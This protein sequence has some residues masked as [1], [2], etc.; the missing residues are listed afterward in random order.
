[1]AT[2]VPDASERLW[3]TDP[4]STDSDKDGVPDAVELAMRCMG[5]QLMCKPR[6]SNGDGV[7]DALDPQVQARGPC[8]PGAGNCLMHRHHLSSSEL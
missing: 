2:G 1:M 5:P 4:H 7:V 3:G 8:D 6:D